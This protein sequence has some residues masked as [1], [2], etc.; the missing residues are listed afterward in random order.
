M[1]HPVS[2]DFLL[3]AL[4]GAAL[5]APLTLWAARLLRR[6]WGRREQRLRRSGRRGLS[7][8]ARFPE[9]PGD[10]DLSPAVG[11]TVDQFETALRAAWS[12]FRR[13]HL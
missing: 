8:A 2:A 12:E 6:M 13:R 3:G 11:G 1:P 4:A 10:S 5:I 7:H 9:R